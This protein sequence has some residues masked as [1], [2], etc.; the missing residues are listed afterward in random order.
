M[1]APFV[2]PANNAEPQPSGD[3]PPPRDRLHEKL[4]QARSL[5]QRHPSDTRALK[6]WTNAAVR[7]G[8][9]RDAR[10]AVDTW[11]LHDSSPEPRV[12]LAN[13]LDQ[14]GKHVEARAVLEEILETHP[15]S[16]PA[17]RLHAKLGAPLPPPDTSA[18]RNATARNER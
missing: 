6:A 16:E 7:A 2:T 14:S 1:Q 3:K 13:V 12:A 15:D 17:R 10:R 8:D 9:Y 11:I 4:D 18:R 5:A